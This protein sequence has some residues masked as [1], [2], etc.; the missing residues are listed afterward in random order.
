MCLILFALDAHP[1]YKLVLAA[2]RDEFYQRPTAP[3]DFWTD[4]PEVFAGRDLAAGGTWLGITKTG[5]LAA[6]TNYRDPNA[7]PGSKSRGDLTREFLTG[8]E[9]SADYLR[10]LA[11][12]RGDY[13]GFNLLVGDFAKDAELFYFSNRGSANAQKLTKGVYGLSN[14]LLDTNWNKVET[15]KARFAKILQMS[16]EIFPADLFSLLSDRAA[17]P[18]AKLP[19]TGVGLERER[20]LSPAFIET[21]N[22]GTRLSTVLTITREGR[23]NFIERTFV[24]AVGEISQE[25]ALEKSPSK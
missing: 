12:E 24:G 25:F 2:N 11:R 3:A 13:S 9:P 22:Y 4:A 17:A 16:D 14:A 6:V 19:A 20:V 15:G 23:I 21:E 10:N 1:L 8:N 5:R 18:D 7:A